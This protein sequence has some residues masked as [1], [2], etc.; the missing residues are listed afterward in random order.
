MTGGT[1]YLPEE[2]MPLLHHRVVQISCRRHCQASVPNGKI[3]VILIVHFHRK[4]LIHQIVVY[5]LLHIPR[6]VP[7][8]EIFIE[9]GLY[10]R[11]GGSFFR[12][13]RS[14]VMVSA[15][16]T[17]HIGYVPYRIGT[18]SIH[19]RPPAQSISKPEGM[20]LLAVALH[21]I[22]ILFHPFAVFEE[23]R[24][25]VHSCRLLPCIFGFKAVI[26]DG[27]EQSGAVYAYG[28]FQFHAHKG[29]VYRFIARFQRDIICRFRYRHLRIDETV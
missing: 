17:C 15:V 24:I 7:F 16:G 4:L 12:V 11:I 2:F 22:G 26:G 20:F 23:S 8:G 27:I 5:I 13:S 1:T 25:D 28:R 29:I 3:Y 6:L 9:F 10:V 18:G 19:Q 14:H 21:G